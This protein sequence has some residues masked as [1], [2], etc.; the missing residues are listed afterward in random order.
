MTLTEIARCPLI[1]ERYPSLAGKGCGTV[2]SLQ[3][4]NAAT[5][6]WKCDQCPAGSGRSD[7][8]STVKPNICDGGARWNQDSEYGRNVCR[9]WTERH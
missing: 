4:R 1:L 2:G 7:G 5:L 8:F 9:I 3:I 6:T